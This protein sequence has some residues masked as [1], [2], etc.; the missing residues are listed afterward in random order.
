[1]G[2][3][4][5]SSFVEII[6]RARY[7]IFVGVVSCSAPLMSF[8]EDVIPDGLRRCSFIDD[9]SARVACYDK[10]SGRQAPAEISPGTSF[11]PSLQ[12]S[13]DDLGSEVLHRDGDDKNENLEVRATV[14]RCSK[15][16]H[17]RYFFYFDNGQVWKQ[18]KN[19][20]LY[21]KGCEFTVTIT[22]DFFG[23]KMQQ[24]GEKRR[25]RISRVK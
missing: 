7:T 14:T 21:F 9:A 18:L 16:A 4:M 8:A 3:C 19:S 11:E 22:K 12:P 24:D 17:D 25:I 13:L 2:K 20:H 1:M 15:G 10:F 23:Y 5:M 6:V